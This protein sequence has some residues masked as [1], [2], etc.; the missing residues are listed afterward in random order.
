MISTIRQGDKL[1]CLSCKKMFKVAGILISTD[2]SRKIILCPHC[3]KS[4]DVQAYHLYGELA[5]DD[6][7]GYPDA[8]NP[9]EIGI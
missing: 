4:F 2:L 5:D 7:E 8:L 6:C 3:K 1:E 9:F